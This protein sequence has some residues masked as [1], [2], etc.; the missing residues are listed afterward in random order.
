MQILAIEHL[1]RNYQLPSSYTLQK[2]FWLLRTPVI[3]SKVWHDVSP[4]CFACRSEIWVQIQTVHAIRHSNRWWDCTGIVSWCRSSP[5]SNTW[6]SY[7]YFTRAFPSVHNSYQNPFRIPQSKHQPTHC[8]FFFK[9]HY[10]CLVCRQAKETVVMSCLL[11][12]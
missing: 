3:S 8:L 4:L 7:F 5:Q 10:G 9:P 2:L 12:Y 1:W 6:L 11:W